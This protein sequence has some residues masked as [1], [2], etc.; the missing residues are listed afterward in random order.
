MHDQR[1]R[2]VG[3][4]IVSPRHSDRAIHARTLGA[5]RF[6]VIRLATDEYHIGMD[7]CAPLT[8]DV[9][10]DCCYAHIK[11]SIEDVAVC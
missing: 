5:S 7:G 11:A 8:E 2:I 6:N 10:Q 4:P 9:L 1:P 3:G